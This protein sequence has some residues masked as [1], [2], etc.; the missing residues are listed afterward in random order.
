MRGLLGVVGILGLCFLLSN[1][2]R[3]IPWA[4][5]AWGLGLQLILVFFILRTQWGHSVFDGAKAFFETVL[6]SSVEGVKFAFGALGDLKV[7]G[8]AFGAEN[9]FIFGIQVT[10]T[11]IF[12]GILTA[13]LYHLGIMQRIVYVIARSMQ[14]T[15]KTSG[16]ESLCSAANIFLGQTEA[17]LTVKPYLED[18]T[19]SEMLAIMIGG[20][21]NVAGGV[22][23]AYVFMGV[24]AGHLL[25]ASVMSA[26]ASLLIAKILIP[27]TSRPKTD[28]KISFKEMKSND[29]N[30]LDALCRGASEGMSLSINVVAMLVGFVALI[31]LVNL[32]IGYV[33]P[34]LTFQT[35]LGYLFVPLSWL[36]GV[37]SGDVLKVAQLIGLKTTLNEFLAYAELMRIKGELSP[38][39]VTLATYAL[40]GFANFSSVGIQIGGISALVPSARKTLSE[41]GMLALVGGTLSSLLTACIAAMFLR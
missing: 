13:G 20:M 10:G 3:K 15:M 1:N 17:P 40:C 31:A 2:R 41:L 26:P 8:R 25:A 35:I 30:L 36:I 22:L 14:V 7:S 32:G 18:V 11:I 38:H 39:S 29:A 4:S 23:A 19:R 9:A 6:A 27:E 24:D 12:V 21:A 33:V 37:E 28:G 5:V 16:A 34:G